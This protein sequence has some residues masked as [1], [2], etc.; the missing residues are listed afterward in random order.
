MMMMM[1]MMPQGA[2]E[3]NNEKGGG[4][5]GFRDEASPPS[6]LVLVGL[7]GDIVRYQLVL[8]PGTIGDTAF[9]GRPPLSRYGG[10]HDLI[11]NN[12]Q[13]N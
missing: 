3:C 13:W 10:A 8:V 7:L 2:D 11:Y 4:Y 1:R 6:D 12:E 5:Y 9:L